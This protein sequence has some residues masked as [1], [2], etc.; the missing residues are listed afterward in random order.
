MQQDR[1][2]KGFHTMAPE[3]KAAQEGP[4]ETHDDLFLIC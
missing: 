1:L 4:P 3:K 2:E